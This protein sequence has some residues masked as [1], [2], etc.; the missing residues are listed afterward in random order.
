MEFLIK[1]RP[2][3][4]PSILPFSNHSF[5]M[6]VTTRNIKHIWIELINILV[7]NI[8][9]SHGCG[10]GISTQWSS[11]GLC[12]GRSGGVISLERHNMWI[13]AINTILKRLRLENLCYAGWYWWWLEFF[14]KK[15]LCFAYLFFLI[16]FLKFSFCFLSTLFSFSLS[17]F[18]FFFFVLCL[19]IFSDLSYFFFLLL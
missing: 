7:R 13:G 1:Y 12:G 16:I 11:R 19:L 4:S 5:P 18:L 9:I 3:L 8:S 15:I 14:K 2:L 17:L 10:R 6:N